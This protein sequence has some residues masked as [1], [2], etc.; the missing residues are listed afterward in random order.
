MKPG[1]VLSR[2]GWIGGVVLAVLLAGSVVWRAQRIP[3]P[4]TETL[5]AV[6]NYYES[7]MLE[8][9]GP[10]STSRYAE[11]AWTLGLPL[12]DTKEIIR[13]GVVSH[14]FNNWAGAHREALDEI[15]R[16]A[17]SENI[18]PVFMQDSEAGHAE[19]IF[20]EGPDLARAY[21]LMASAATQEEDW[22]EALLRLRHSAQ[23]SDPIR[24]RFQ[25]GHLSS[26]AGRATGYEG[27]YSILAHDLPAIALEQALSDLQAL[28]T[29]EPAFDEWHRLAMQA[30]RAY[31]LLRYAGQ[32]TV[33]NPL[34]PAVPLDHRI[35]H[36][37]LAKARRLAAIAAGDF[38]SPSLRRYAER[39]RA[40]IDPEQPFDELEW[41]EGSGERVRWT[42]VPADVRFLR[43]AAEAEPALF[44]DMALPDHLL[45]TIDR[46]TL[47]VYVGSFPNW[48]A[49]NT[50]VP[51]R[52]TLTEGELLRT[53][54]DARLQYSQAGT[55]PETVL[56]DGE[57]ERI[58]NEYRHRTDSPYL[59]IQSRIIEGELP[60]VHFKLLLRRELGTAAR[61][62]DVELTFDDDPFRFRLTYPT[63]L[64]AAQMLDLRDALGPFT[65]KLEAKIIPPQVTLPRQIGCIVL[66]EEFPWPDD[67]SS[68]DDDSQ[69]TLDY[70]PPP[71]VNIYWAAYVGPGTPMPSPLTPETAE[72]MAHVRT[73]IGDRE[74]RFR[75]WADGVKIVAE[76]V[77]A[78]P[79]DVRILWSP[80][81][82]G[83]DGR[84]EIPYDPTNG[85]RSAGD[86]I[87]FP[88][89][90]R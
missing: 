4:D 60:R 72:R 40:D 65:E 74:R 25:L 26:V 8:V 64:T 87:V 3:P 10:P 18:Y 24:F 57:F 23:S 13:R 48:R 12:L 11:L 37:Y 79:E 19:R 21:R 29:T 61:S 53:A 6:V 47:A 27:Y 14:E 38:E 45:E 49:P 31:G 42:F 55:W 66:P 75:I 78:P 81:P 85:T 44:K 71:P 69:S 7:E 17:A 88:E 54:F 77:L 22:D 73:T 63:D 5:Q 39:L 76:G 43:E 89:S 36:R 15:G 82:D 68:S 34:P 50:E 9:F 90:F 84:G 1:R 46:W 56:G 52:L 80:G 58:V 28:Q 70:R 35:R 83:L 59:P 20:S 41:A 51:P 33:R 30:G 62:A 16:L 2:Y 67:V 32:D 86:I